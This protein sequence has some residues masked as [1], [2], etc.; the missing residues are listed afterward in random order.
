MPTLLQDSQ[1]RTEATQ[2]ALVPKR[3]ATVLV[4]G[5]SGLLGTALCTALAG[6]G[7]RVVRH[8]RSLPPGDHLAFP[9]ENLALIEPAVREQK[10]DWIIHAAGNTSVDGCEQEPGAA[11]RLHVEASAELA[12]AARQHG[13]RLLYVSTDSVYDGERGGTHAEDDPL[14]PCNLYA[15]TKREGELACREALD[16]TLV[17]RVNFFGLHPY[18]RQG[19]AAWIMTELQAGRGI[20]GFTDVFFNPL[21]NHD[22]AALIV[23][24]IH[25]D[26]PGGVYNFGAAD[27]CSKY[28]FARR[29][30]L[31][32][33][34]DA[35]LVSPSAI[36]SAA[37]QA[38]RPRNT[39]MD[40]R[41]L[42]AALRQPMPTIRDGLL[43]LVGTVASKSRS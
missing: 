15:L 18:R 23:R 21:G 12:R 7:H 1:L 43:R 16:T 2:V 26:L 34:L 8:G 37:L 3:S 10:P 33:G 39:V 4:T 24:A 35:G 32:L 25:N 27:S 31:L 30:A 11:R 13:S 38:R 22:L 36:V 28:D 42:T 14:V 17:A 40:I 20:N 41:K 6:E 9:L 5:A 29:I 19:L